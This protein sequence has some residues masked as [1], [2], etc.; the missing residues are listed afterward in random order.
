MNQH[1]VCICSANAGPS[2]FA[3]TEREAA[4]LQIPAT[5]GQAILD[6]NVKEA[7][8]LPTINGCRA[9]RRVASASAQPRRAEDYT[10]EKGG[11]GRKEAAVGDVGV[12]VKS[13]STMPV[14]L[15]RHNG[16]AHIS[17][18][19]TLHVCMC[20]CETRTIR[21]GVDPIS[22][23]VTVERLYFIQEKMTEEREG[24]KV[25]EFLLALL[26]PTFYSHKMLKSTFSQLSAFSPVDVGASPAALIN[27]S[28]CCDLINAIRKSR[29]RVG[30]G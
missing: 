15:R 5:S 26:F 29:G 4:V 6:L 30:P 1:F 17:L 14:I 8:Y 10:C 18:P 24:A 11:M 16:L 27:L 25:G 7:L 13:R 21:V 12:E 19:N 28:R 2:V 22:P 23:P 3:D 20:G 9:S